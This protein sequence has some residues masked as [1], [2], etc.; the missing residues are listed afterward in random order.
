MKV[1]Y[2]G[3]IGFLAFVVVFILNGI[4][5]KIICSIIGVPVWTIFEKLWEISNQNRSIFSLIIAVWGVLLLLL[6]N[7][8]IKTFFNRKWKKHK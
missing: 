2:Y 6:A 3:L 1:F 5:V 7:F 4:V 8:L